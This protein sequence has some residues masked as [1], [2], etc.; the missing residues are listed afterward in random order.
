MTVKDVKKTQNGSSESLLHPSF[1]LAK[2]CFC[3]RAGLHAQKTATPGSPRQ[4][5]ITPDLLHILMGD[6]AA[7]SSVG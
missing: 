4:G 5:C 2:A 6:H 7:H 1:V 3:P